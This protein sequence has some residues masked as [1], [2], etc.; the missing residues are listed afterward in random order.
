MASTAIVGEPTICFM[1]LPGGGYTSSAAKDSS[2][3]S[4]ATAMPFIE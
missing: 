2:T 3:S 1:T 4:S